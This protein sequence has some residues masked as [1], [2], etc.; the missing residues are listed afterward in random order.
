VLEHIEND[1]RAL[2]ELCE[3]LVPGGKINLLVP[4]HP[5]LFCSLDRNL[6]HFRRYQ[7][8]EL[9]NRLQDAGFIIEK[10]VY[11]NWIGSL[12]WWFYGCILR[13]GYITKVATRGFRLVSFLQ[14]F[15]EYLD[16]PFGLSL[17]VVAKR[18]E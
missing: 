9:L 2:K 4:A 10:C 17:E 12:G 1:D 18:P 13:R 15:E 6:G 14:S 7:R 3:V 11:Q 16:F 5:F 8:Q